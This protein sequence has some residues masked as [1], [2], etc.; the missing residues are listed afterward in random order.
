M[1]P[2]IPAL[3]RASYLGET[4]RPSEFDDFA[5]NHDEASET[6]LARTLEAEEAAEG[7]F[8]W[9]AYNLPD[10][11]ATNPLRSLPPVY[12]PTDDE[13]QLAANY[14]NGQFGGG[15][16]GYVL[17]QIAA[18]RVGK[19]IEQHQRRRAALATLQASLPDGY[20]L[21]PAY[22]E[23]MQS[24]DAIDRLRHNTLWI[25]TPHC[26]E[27]LPTAEH[28]LM[29]PLLSEGQGCINGQLLLTPDGDHVVTLSEYPFGLPPEYRGSQ[30]AAETYSSGLRAVWIAADEFGEW[31]VAYF[32]DCCE[33]DA[34]YEETCRFWKS[35][36]TS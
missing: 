35:M 8:D 29:V 27:P 17:G 9:P 18:F 12:V 2:L 21:P 19:P 25:S 34:H 3:P 5:L 11:A 1:S 4:I 16:K 13:R 15:A 20:V 10:D 24:D 14:R 28:C 32:Q 31:L 6:A 23:L 22:I 7:K 36:G 30:S 33:G 26:Y